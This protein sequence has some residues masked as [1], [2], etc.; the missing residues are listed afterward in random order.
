MGADVEMAF[1]RG[2]K[3]PAEQTYSLA[4]LGKLA[5]KRA[6]EG[7]QGGEGFTHC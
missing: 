5:A 7:G 3:G 4:W 2:V 1:V 6:A